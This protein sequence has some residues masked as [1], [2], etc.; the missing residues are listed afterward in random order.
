MLLLHIHPKLLNPEVCARLCIHS[1]YYVV[2]MQPYVTVLL[3]LV[4][5]LLGYYP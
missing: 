4:N 5:M 3:G 2:D 1:Y